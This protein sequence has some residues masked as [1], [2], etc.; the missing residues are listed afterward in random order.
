MFL[1]SIVQIPPKFNLPLYHHPIQIF[2]L[3]L[4]SNFEIIL[5]KIKY[6]N[7]FNLDYYHFHNY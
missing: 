5:N 7:E 6:F 4:G 1:N 2:I 3:I